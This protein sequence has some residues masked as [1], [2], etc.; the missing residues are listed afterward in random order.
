MSQVQPRLPFRND[1][2]LGVCEGL[3]EDFG[4]HAN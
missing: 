4:F 3:G 2:F 1:T